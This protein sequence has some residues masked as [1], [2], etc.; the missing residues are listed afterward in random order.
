[1]SE[2]GSLPE[3]ALHKSW[4]VLADKTTCPYRLSPLAGSTPIN[5]GEQDSD[6]TTTLLVELAPGMTADSVS[7]LA[8]ALASFWDLALGAVVIEAIPAKARRIRI[9]IT[10]KVSE[11][12]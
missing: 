11:A 4:K 10:Q 12:A 5:V 1:M 2:N 8:N 7:H 6:G 3:L 9:E